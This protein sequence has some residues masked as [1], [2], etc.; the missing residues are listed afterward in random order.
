M[1]SK[2]LLCLLMIGLL[3]SSLGIA[4]AFSLDTNQM[5]NDSVHRWTWKGK[6]FENPVYVNL[7]NFP[8]SAT[9]LNW[10]KVAQESIESINTKANE[11]GIY[12][13]FAFTDELQLKDEIIMVARYNS[14]TVDPVT[15][16]SNAPL[17]RTN[18]YNI[19]GSSG[20]IHIRSSGEGKLMIYEITKTEVIINTYYPW[21][22]NGERG[23]SY[24]LETTIVHELGHAAG[25]GHHTGSNSTMSPLNYRG[26]QKRWDT[27]DVNGL[28]A[29][30]GEREGPPVVIP[31]EEI[32]NKVEEI[33]ENTVVAGNTTP[34]KENATAKEYVTT[35]ISKLKNWWAN[36]W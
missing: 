6:S 18:P 14:G 15:N 32:S 31:E 24:D 5:D 10:Q 3:A 16:R 19:S 12:A 8:T 33:R 27:D 1:K 25:L 4:S 34:I 21:S 26:E 11:D 35:T 13:D 36:L 7:A 28:I 22:R 9:S 20:L 2:L 29:I 17:G 30:Y 23:V